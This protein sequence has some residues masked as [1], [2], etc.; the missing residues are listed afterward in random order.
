MKRVKTGVVGLDVLLNGGLPEGRT[1]MVAGQ[2]GTGK[3]MLAYHFIHQAFRD[4]HPSLLITLEQSK[5][6]VIADAKEIGID[7]AAMEKA[8]KLRIVGG[9]FGNLQY[10]K[11]KARA[12]VQDLVAEIGEILKESGAKHVAVD[13]V[14]LLTMLF[15][16]DSERRIILSSLIYILEE[17]GCTSLLT[18]E[19]PEDS[20]RFGWFGFEEFMVDGVVSLSRKPFDGNIERTITVIKMRGSAH[21][22][23]VRA[24]EIRDKGLVVYPDQEPASVRLTKHA[25]E[26]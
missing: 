14:N 11:D 26:R 6:K 18:C 21:S 17:A 10:F 16:Q 7:L 12:K 15:D 5:D 22:A 24:M 1:V 20:R 19:V 13:S 4:H 2:C 25:F 23:G 3:T 8:G 9:S